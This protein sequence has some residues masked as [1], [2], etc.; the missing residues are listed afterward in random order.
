MIRHTMVVGADDLSSAAGA[1]VCR[2]LSLST[3]TGPASIRRG[4]PVDDALVATL[5]KQPGA[6]LE[7]VLPEAGE[8][9]QGDASRE[10]A[11]TIVGDGL[12][13]DPPHQGQC[14]V[15]ASGPGVLRVAAS[16]VARINRRRAI[17]LVTAL[18]GRVVNAEDTVGIVKAAHLWTSSEEIARSGRV[19]GRAPVLRVAPFTARQAA[20]LAGPR[21]RARNFRAASDNL[22]GLLQNFGI[23]LTT[24][25]QISD[26]PAAIAQ[27]Y[28]GFLDNGVDIVLI[29]GSIALDPG[30]PFL[31]ALER[32]EASLD[33]LGAPIDPG[34]MFW[35]ATARATVVFG[36][37]SCELYGRRSILDLVLPYAAAKEPV[38]SD[39]LAELGYGGLLEQTFDARRGPASQ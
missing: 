39:L 33:C 9:A 24:A 16:R 14:V 26:D 13:I 25:S 1:L 21:I 28:R 17:L 8:L 36:L 18:D 7:V 3:A 30:D 4:T 11:E 5:A 29:G 12:A 31:V 6:R 2:D 32:V 15:R 20:F 23:D 38:T 34:T 10:F 37:A 35:V 19:A 27:A 22:R